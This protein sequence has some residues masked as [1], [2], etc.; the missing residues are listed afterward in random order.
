MSKAG[1]EGRRRMSVLFTSAIDFNSNSSLG[2]SA[3]VMSQA[4]ASEE[5]GHDVCISKDYGLETRI[6]RT[7]SGEVVASHVRKSPGDR[8]SKYA[9]LGDWARANGVEAV[10]IRFDHLDSVFCS[11]SKQLRGH[12]IALAVEFPTFPFELERDA[13]HKRLLESRKYLS[14]AA[15]RAYAQLES[16]RAKH[17]S[18]YFDY[19]ITYLEDDTIWGVPNITYDNGIDLAAIP[20]RE[21]GKPGET[22]RLLA[23][24][25]FAPHHGIDRLIRG[26][27][28]YK[29]ERPVQ[30]TLV[31]VGAENPALEKLVSELRLGD[32]VVFAGAATGSKLDAFFDDADIAVGSLGLHR[33]GISLGSTMKSREYCAR[34]IPFVYSFPE[35][36][37]NGDE[38]FTLMFSS[39]D[40]PIPI[41]EVIAFADRMAA[42]PE[43][44]SVMRA[45]AEEHFDWKVQMDKVLKVLETDVADREG[46]IG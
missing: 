27:A 46:K 20:L 17:A 39:N 38:K 26:L 45:F 3:K 35:K 7:C 32:S 30:L 14:Y 34:G 43:T 18:R 33:I 11:F 4:K 29:G 15:H 2:I 31:G 40:D 8:R 13:R 10:V 22:V 9:F 1:T 24:A 19:A 25:K 41:D 37:F 16:C 44:G 12:G 36:G 28:E 23:V 5:A 42:D 21:A 6:E